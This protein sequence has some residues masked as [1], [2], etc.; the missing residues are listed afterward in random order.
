MDIDVQL[1][2]GGMLRIDKVGAGPLLESMHGDWDREE[3]VQID[4]GA[5][6]L[7]YLIREGLAGRGL[8]SARIQEL[9]REAG[10]RVSGWAGYAPDSL[11]VK[12]RR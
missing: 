1:E 3:I 5:Q 10:L 7:P 4:D 12:A 2:P 9:A 11:M 8:T 6:L